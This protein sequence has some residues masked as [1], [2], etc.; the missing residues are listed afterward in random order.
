[1]DRQCLREVTGDDYRAT[2]LDESWMEKGAGMRVAGCPRVQELAERN[3]L[4][5]A[6]I[7]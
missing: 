2:T 7:S 5:K 4:A 1:M 3:V 6:K